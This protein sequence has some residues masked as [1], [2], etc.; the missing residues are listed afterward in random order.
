[1]THDVYTH[2]LTHR[3]MK[4][5]VRIDVTK[6][7]KEWLYKGAKGT[8]LDVTVHLK[9]APDQYGNDG[10]AVQQAPKAEYDAGK[11]GL[12]LG[13]VRKLGQA[14]AAAPSAASQPSDW[15][16]SQTAPDEDLPF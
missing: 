14:P 11:R 12:I 1:M 15:N 7:E 8:Y 5:T 2:K 3:K 9:D 4:L 16:K 10:F 13:N 6:I